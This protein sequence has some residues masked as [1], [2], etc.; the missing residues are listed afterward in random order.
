MFTVRVWDLPLRLFHWL[1]V[2]C[3]VGMLVTARLDWMEWHMRCGYLIF[4]LILFRLCWG[5]VGGY[6]GRFAH[7]VPSPASLLTYLR[8]ASAASTPVGHNPLGA[9]SVLAMLTVLGLQLASG[10][11]ADDEIAAAGPLVRHL[12]SAWVSAATYYHTKVGKFLLLGLIVLHIAAIVKYQLQGSNL[13]LPM[14]LG[15]KQLPFVA[16]SSNDGWPQRVLALFVL[17]ACT[18]GV[19]L[20]VQALN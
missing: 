18:V 6:W 9:L 3:L 13:V 1:L 4:D 19:Y 16:I 12:D 2:S 17:A 14:V 15:D 20:F 10:M 7:F 5:F 11:A 8:G